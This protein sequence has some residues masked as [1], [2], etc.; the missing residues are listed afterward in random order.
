MMHKAQASV[1]T[2]NGSIDINADF[3]YESYLFFFETIGS[4]VISLQNIVKIQNK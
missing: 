1:S 4:K 2:G 3:P